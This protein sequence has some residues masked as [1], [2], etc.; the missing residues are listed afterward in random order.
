L[1]VRTFAADRQLKGMEISYLSY[2][3]VAEGQT[4]KIQDIRLEGPKC[5]GD[6]GCWSWKIP[7]L[8][9]KK[10]TRKNTRRLVELARA[11]PGVC[12]IVRG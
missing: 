4:W 9:K 11:R 5:W 7:S 1:D 3:L 2:K 12:F 8:L 10:T 6:G